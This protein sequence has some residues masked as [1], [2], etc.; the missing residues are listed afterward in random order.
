MGKGME[1]Y[2]CCHSLLDN[3]GATSVLSFTD[4]LPLFLDI[5]KNKMNNEKSTVLIYV[6]SFFVVGEDNILPRDVCTKERLAFPKKQVDFFIK[7]W[8]NKTYTFYGD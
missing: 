6:R 8:Y 5:P 4:L 1:Y 3:L 2:P 7:I